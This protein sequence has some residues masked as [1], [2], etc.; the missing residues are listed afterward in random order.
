MKPKNPKFS[1]IGI[2]DDQAV[3]S[4]GGRIGAMNGPKSFLKVWDKLNGK[5][6]LKNFVFPMLE[7]DGLTADIKNNHIL[8]SL[9]VKNAHLVSTR[10]II[11]GGS[12]DHGYSHLLGVYDFLKTKLKRKPKIG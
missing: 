2:A 5:V 6:T 4:L 3:L 7:V 10:T 9:C 11:I 12:H 1:L 8:A